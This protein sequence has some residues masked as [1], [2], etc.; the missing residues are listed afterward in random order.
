MEKIRRLGRTYL[1]V[2]RSGF[3]AIP[4]QRIGFD[5]ADYLLQKAFNHGINFY[6]TARGYTDSEEKI[7]RALGGV[8]DR[9]VIATKSGATDRKTLQEHLETSLKNLRTDYI[10]IYQFHNPKKVPR[11]GDTEEW[12]EF[13]QAAKAAGK[14][15]FIGITNHRLDLAETAV[16]SGLYDTLQ[17]PLNYLSSENELKLVDRCKE[18]NIG[19]IAMKGL[20]GGLITHAAAAF[21]FLRQFDNVVP[22]W[23][24]QRETEL[25]EF[26]AWEQNPPV[27]D[28]K[29]EQVIQSDRIE[30]AGDF[31]RGCGYCLPCP[32]G[33]PIP[34]AARMTFLLRRSFY[35]Q[36]L[37]EEWRNKM[38][39]IETCIR[40]GQCKS[41]CPYELDTPGLLKKMYSE[42][43]DFYK[44]HQA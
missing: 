2:S 16:E 40:C 5:E 17:F 23:G 34:M 44:Q 10:D 38:E 25:D 12:Y 42:Y 21:A 13:A 6:D 30:L 22:I 39:L 19:L 36:Y 20:S 35:Q 31:C 32:A 26:I 28:Q 33:I 7:G 29:L 15:R 1:Q 37:Q 4:I 14:I 27:L 3:G 41:R 11:A 9:I 18:N 43:Q 24:I 8:R